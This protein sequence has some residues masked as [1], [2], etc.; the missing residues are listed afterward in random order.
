MARKSQAIDT[1]FK[2]FFNK[3]YVIVQYLLYL[4][5]A[6]VRQIWLCFYRPCF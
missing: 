3:Y 4:P 2:D 6:I 5:D 1:S